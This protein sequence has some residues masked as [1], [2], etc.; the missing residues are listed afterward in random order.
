MKKLF[1]GLLIIVIIIIVGVMGYNQY[2]NW[3]N[4]NDLAEQAVSPQGQL[5]DNIIPTHYDLSL[6]VNPEEGRFSGSVAISVT[7]TEDLK[8]LWL[9]GKD[10]DVSL[11]SFTSEQGETFPLVYEEMGHSGVVSLVSSQLLAAQNGIISIEFSGQLADD[12]AGLYKVEEA[13]LA[14]VFS[15]FEATD[16]RART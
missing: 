15:Q 16:A 4:E 12:L 9:H 6:R 10:F 13:G 14:Y 11:A 8:Q 2:S 3:Q 5:P 7:L 1:K